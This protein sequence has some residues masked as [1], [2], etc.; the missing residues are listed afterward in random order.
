MYEQMVLIR[1]YEEQIYY[2]FLEGSMPGSIHQSQGQEAC[3]VGTLFDLRG[4]DYAGSTHRPAGHCLAK[5]VSL[6][7]MMCEMFAKSNGCCGAK[8][9]AMHTGDITKGMLPA[10]AIVAGN[11]PIM[12][13][14]A[15]SFKIRGTDQVAVSFFGDGA[16]NE[17]AFHEALNGAAIWKLPVI[18]VCE[19]NLY[20]ASTPISTTCLLQNPAA[21]RGS[22]Y[23][24]PGFV[25]DGNDVIAVNQAMEDAV[26]RARAGQ[27][28]T[29]LELKTYRT[30]GHSR[31]DSCA[32]RRREEEAEWLAKDPIKKLGEYLLQSGLCAQEEL[33]D[34]EQRIE[35]QV[36]DAVEFAKNSPVPLPQDALHNVYWEKDGQ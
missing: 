32:Y 15:L 6:E 36:E 11:M 17:G 35:N 19:N 12:C 28:P 31:N 16:T 20:G 8:G 29:I 3:A 14:V 18:F 4:D 13:G 25:V 2:L 5:G 22:A 7:S 1:K 33:T 27:G 9:G 23:G 34:I 21:D 26:K 10:N 24:I 30:G